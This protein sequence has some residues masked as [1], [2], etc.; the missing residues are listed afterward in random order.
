MKYKKKPVVIE[1]FRF[2]YDSIPPWFVEAVHNGIVKHESI[3]SPFGT[4]FVLQ[5]NT[6]EGVMTAHHGDY[7]IKGVVGELYPFKPKIFE[8]TYELVG[9]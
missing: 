9:E 8:E 2:G 1:A 4:T 3:P 7:I 5:I 6:L